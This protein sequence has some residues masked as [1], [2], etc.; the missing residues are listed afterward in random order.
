[1][2]NSLHWQTTVL[3]GSRIEVSSPELREG[4]RVEVVVV[5]PPQSGAAPTGVLN[6]LESLPMGPRSAANW[7]DI[8]RQYQEE[9]SAWDR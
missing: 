5:L 1:M 6:Y 2:S 3:P 9:R 8:D 4:D 7:D